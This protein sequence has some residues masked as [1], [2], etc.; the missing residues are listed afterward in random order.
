M[1]P[2]HPLFDTLIEWAIREARQAGHMGFR[3]TSPSYLLNCIA[4]ESIAECR[5]SVADFLAS[6][7]NQQS[8]IENVQAWA[9]E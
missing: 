1:A 8:Q 3:T 5:S 9:Y 4:T 6:I 2:G 7:E